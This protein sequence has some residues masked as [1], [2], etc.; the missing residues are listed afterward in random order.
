MMGSS[1]ARTSV[2]NVMSNRKQRMSDGT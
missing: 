1:T 2:Q